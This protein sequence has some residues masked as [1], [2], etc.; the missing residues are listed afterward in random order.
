MSDENGFSLLDYQHPVSALYKPSQLGRYRP[1]SLTLY[2]TQVSC[3]PILRRPSHTY[4]LIYHTIHHPRHYHHIRHLQLPISQHGPP[5]LLRHCRI[6]R[7]LRPR[8][9]D[10]HRS[11]RRCCCRSESSTHQPRFRSSTSYAAGLGYVLPSTREICRALA[12]H[13][14]P[15]VKRS[16]LSMPND[17]PFS[18]TRSVNVL[19]D[20]QTDLH[21]LID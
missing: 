4:Q 16:S 14:A 19:L 6:I 9:A 11:C 3:Q 1:L 13:T 5:R 8:R 20:C 17:D 2:T 15:K 18:G 10:H 12:E 7:L 21:M